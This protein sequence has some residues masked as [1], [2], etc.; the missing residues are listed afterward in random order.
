MERHGG[1]LERQARG[2]ERE[3]DRHADADVTAIP[4]NRSQRVDTEVAPEKPYT[5]EQP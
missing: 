2:D 3:A 1:N 4:E 5:I